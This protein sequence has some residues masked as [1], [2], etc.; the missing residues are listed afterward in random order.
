MIIDIQVQNII[1]MMDI[2]GND[3]SMIIIIWTKEKMS[4]KEILLIIWAINILIDRIEVGAEVR[5]GGETIVD[6]GEMK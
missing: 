1:M 4:I 5:V 2:I 3:S 6:I